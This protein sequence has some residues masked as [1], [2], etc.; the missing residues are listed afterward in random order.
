MKNKDKFVEADAL[1]LFDA[2]VLSAWHSLICKVVLF[3][4]EKYSHNRDQ[5]VAHD[6]YRCYSA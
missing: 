2:V 3:S 4:D 1:N 5:I 6:K